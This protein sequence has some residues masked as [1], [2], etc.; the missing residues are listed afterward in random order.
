MLT[1]KTNE[2][3]LEEQLPVFK[4]SL[5]IIDSHFVKDSKFIAGKLSKL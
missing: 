3:R 1:G 5:K 2:R 4:K